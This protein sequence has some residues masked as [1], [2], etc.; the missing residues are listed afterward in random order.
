MIVIRWTRGGSYIVA[1][2]NGAVIWRK[3]AA[4]RVVPYSAREKIAIPS[5]I[6]DF[7]DIAKQCL[8]KIIDGT[9]DQSLHF[10]DMAFEN[11]PLHSD[12]DE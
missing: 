5:S 3:A 7:I 6:L 8:R 4:F 10:K 1:E 9:E 11:A 12:E 2:M